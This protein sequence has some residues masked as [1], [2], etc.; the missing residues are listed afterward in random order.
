MQTLKVIVPGE[1]Y[2]SQIYNGRLYLWEIDGSLIT[3]DWDKLVSK[4]NVS[5]ELEIALR[6]ALQH[7][8]ALYR[9]TL[10]QDIEVK[11]LMQLKFKKLSELVIEVNR[12]DLL[13]CAVDKQDSPFPFPHADSAIHYKVM[14][15]GSQDGVSASSCIKSNQ[16]DG[17]EQAEKLLDLPVLSLAT[18]HSTLAIAAGNEGLFDYSL[19]QNS[20]KKYGEPHQLSSNH[21]NLTRWLYPSIFGSS[22]FNDGYFADF[23]AKKKT[24]KENAVLNTYSNNEHG[25]RQKKS[26]QYER[27]FQNLV[28]SDDIFEQSNAKPNGVGSTETGA[29]FT[30]GVQDKLCSITRSSVKLAQYKSSSRSKDTRRKFKDL[31]SVEIKG[32]TSEVISADSSSFGIVLEQ[33]DGLLIVTSLLESHFLQGEP[34][35]W[36]VFPKAKN[37]SN[38]LH[39][40]YDDALYIY[41]FSHDYFVDQFT[42]KLGTTVPSG[43]KL[44]I[45]EEILESSSSISFED[46]FE[47]VPF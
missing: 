3:V 33:E 38:H 4:I 8:D 34:I 31:G 27:I 22:Y 40:I 45:P 47:D 18:S 36:R 46:A 21:C 24:I 44:V 26:P 9:N 12:T 43:A 37:Y 23:T 42:K 19:I 11:D 41:A 20:T 1:F 32:L 17:L 15:V 5:E 29:R 25:R 10:L 28:S 13:L 6:F 7:N 14:Y 39:V 30:W 16:W 2:D 35:N